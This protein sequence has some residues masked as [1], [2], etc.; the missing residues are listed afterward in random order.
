MKGWAM[1]LLAVL[2]GCSGGKADVPQ[3]ALQPIGY[4]DVTQQK[5]YG[6]GCNF[7]PAGGGMGALFMA[8]ETRGLIKLDDHLVAMPT[9]ADAAAL[10]HGAHTHYAGPLYGASLTPLAGGRHKQ[11]GVVNVFDA[12]LVIS[13]ARGQTV[14]AADG[15][16][17]CKPM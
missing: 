9:A 12:H 11:L 14:Y 4:F 8:M 3:L 13:D 7:V 17:Q 10:P 5:L 1:G 2:A 16:V 15:E 6:S